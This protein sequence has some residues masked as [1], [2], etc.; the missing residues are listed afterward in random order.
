[1]TKTYK[2]RVYEC[3]Y[4]DTRQV[5]PVNRYFTSQQLIRFASEVF[6]K[7]IKTVEEACHIINQN[8]GYAFEIFIELT[9]EDFVDNIKPDGTISPK[10]NLG[11]FEGQVP[12]SEHLIKNFDKLLTEQQ[13]VICT[14]LDKA[15]QLLEAIRNEFS[16]IDKQLIQ[17]K[18][19]E[20]L[21]TFVHDRFAEFDR[22]DTDSQIMNMRKFNELDDDVLLELLT[23]VV[24]EMTISDL[25]EDDPLVL[26]SYSDDFWHELIVTRL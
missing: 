16:G 6:N 14:F 3:K 8:N 11:H 25:M 10:L 2:I 12:K 17:S 18:A 21:K 4:Y 19:I 24:N 5:E 13:R 22:P 7:P 15:E 23:A 1:M 26:A 9:N 20:I